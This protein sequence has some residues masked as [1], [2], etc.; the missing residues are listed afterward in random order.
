M[1][2]TDAVISLRKA[3]VAKILV[4]DDDALVCDVL[5][6]CLRE[7]LGAEVKCA[8]TGE[9]GALMITGMRFDLTLIDALLPDV[10]GIALAE[11]AADEDTAALMMSGHPKI[12]ETLDRFD[13]PHLEKPFELASL[14]AE[15]TNIMRD[16]RK[17]IRRVKASAVQMRASSEAL[18]AAMEKAWRLLDAIKVRQHDQ[19][20]TT[21]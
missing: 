4:V 8:L 6:G 3:A 13:F 19:D 5:T 2:S 18:N 20:K 14:V 15:A 1:G 16:T 9:H 11:F 21:G 17:N 10:S 12:N 7:D